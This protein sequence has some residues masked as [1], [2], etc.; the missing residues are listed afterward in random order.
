MPDH[1]DKRWGGR[2]LVLEA[3][4]FEAG[5]LRRLTELRFT[6]PSAAGRPGGRPALLVRSTSPTSIRARLTRNGP[7]FL[8]GR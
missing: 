5:S 3:R 8:R 1:D 2:P 7:G 6:P 4:E